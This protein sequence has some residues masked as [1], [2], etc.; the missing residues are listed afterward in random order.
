MLHV[1]FDRVTQSEK[2][3]LSTA[4]AVDWRLVL[5]VVDRRCWQQRKGRAKSNEWRLRGFDDIH[6]PEP[7]MYLRWWSLI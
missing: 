2:P 5:L 7:L 1:A 3:S 4:A 6:R